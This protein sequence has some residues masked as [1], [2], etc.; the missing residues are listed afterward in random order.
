MAWFATQDPHMVAKGIALIGSP[1]ERAKLALAI[2]TINAGLAPDK[3][4]KIVSGADDFNEEIV[5][6]AMTEFKEEFKEALSETGQ[7]DFS[8]AGKQ[9]PTNTNSAQPPPIPK[10]Q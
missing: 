2:N 8:K 9:K 4:L 7:I 6:Q 1:A 5:T 10:Q 3:Q